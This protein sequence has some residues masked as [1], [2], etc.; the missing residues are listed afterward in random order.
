MLVARYSRTGTYAPACFSRS[1]SDCTGHRKYRDSIV[2]GHGLRADGG[3]KLTDFVMGD[4]DTLW[5]VGKSVN[6]L[7][8]RP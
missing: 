1:L 8:V 5:A 6:T 2:K 7:K 4:G 3:E